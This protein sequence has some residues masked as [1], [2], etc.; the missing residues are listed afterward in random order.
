[1]HHRATINNVTIQNPDSKPFI[2]CVEILYGKII[3]IC[4]DE[5]T[6]QKSSPLSKYIIDATGLTLTPGLID[7]HIH[8]GYGINFNTASADEMLHFSKKILRHGTTSFLATIMTDSK[9]QIKKQLAEVAKAIKIQHENP[10]KGFARIEGV[11][12][13]GP[14]INS[15]CKGI[16]QPENMIIPTAENLLELVEEAGLRYI[17]I[18][19]YAP[20][21]DRDNEFS[22]FI[23][24][25][26][27][28][29]SAGHTNAS[30]EE[31]QASQKSG[32]SQITHLFNAMPPI[33][34]RNPGIVTESL[35]N[36]DLYVEI[37]ADNEH[38]HPMIIDLALRTKPKDKIIFI[39]DSLP[40]N[41]SRNK[42]EPNRSEI[43]AQQE[44][45]NTGGKAL[46]KDGT[47]AG[48]L[49]FLDDNLRKNS[50]H[51]SFADFLLYASLNPSRNLG[52]DAKGLIKEG[53]DADFVLWDSNLEAK[54]VFVNGI[55][56]EI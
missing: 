2:G 45:F 31:I 44:I 8:G 34:H 19:S 4:E 11:H 46:N 43:F 54:K 16:H 49:S 22:K 38:L 30:C 21:F 10:Q 26:G 27:I 39:S 37:I 33:H 55:V 41:R 36:N 6:C 7:Q 56:Y 48:S 53:Y 14:F 15:D 12:L 23:S 51:I 13:E 29:A 47:L 24:S 50:P 3:S 40:L 52:L 1:M 42:S 18:I 5:I 25:K 28:I 35:L 20:E 9:E 17:K 32:L